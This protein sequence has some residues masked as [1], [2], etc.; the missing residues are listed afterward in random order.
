M[1]GLIGEFELA[2]IKPLPAVVCFNAVG[3][4]EVVVISDLIK[5]RQPF[6]SL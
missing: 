2:E 1:S 4:G 5:K 3:D 6:N